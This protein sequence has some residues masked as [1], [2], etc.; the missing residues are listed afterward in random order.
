M[1]HHAPLGWLALARGTL[2]RVALNRRDDTWLDDAWTASGTRV[3]VVDDGRA[4]VTDGPEP[5]LVLVPPD[6]APDG[7]RWLLGEDEDGTVYFGTSGPLPT[8]EGA[9]PVGLRRVGALLGDRDSGLLTHAVA[10]ENWHR[11]HLHCTRCGAAT[12]VASAGHV[13]VCP[14]DGSQ[15]FPRVDPA[16]IMLVTDEA[17]RILLARGP[18]WPADRRSILAGFVE[19]GESLEQAVAREVHEE[20]GLSVRDIRYLGSQPWP[21]PQS[22][23]LGFTARADGDV[24]LRPDPEEISDAAWYTRA[25][26]RTAIDTGELVAPGPLSIAA[27]L[28]MRWYGGPLPDMP[29]VF[30]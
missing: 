4:L 12:R 8:I 25:E 30:A 3:V 21:L 17:D 24:P 23:M 22:L 27:Q 19:P 7:D 15:H 5:A 28:I 11:T 1:T 13:R 9:R 29:A 26:L 14:E 10:L 6:Q 20:V 16:V 18:Q 2:D